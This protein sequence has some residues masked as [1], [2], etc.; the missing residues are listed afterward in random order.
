MDR[1][2]GLSS[3]GSSEDTTLM[4]E[5]RIQKNIEISLT[6]M[7]GTHGVHERKRSLQPEASALPGLQEVCA[8]DKQGFYRHSWN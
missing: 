8:V 7:C 6:K 3:L 5:H 2:V 4:A 1:K